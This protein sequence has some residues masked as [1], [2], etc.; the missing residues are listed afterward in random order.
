MPDGSVVIPPALPTKERIAT[1]DAC[2][3][4]PIQTEHGGQRILQRPPAPGLQASIR[5][6]EVTV[7]ADTGRPP[8]MCAPAFLVVLLTDTRGHGAVASR[9]VRVRALG[10]QR[11]VLTSPA[12]FSAPP[13]VVRAY[14][15][16]ADGRESLVS[17][18]LVR[19]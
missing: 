3:A 10:P 19:P 17:S 16:T 2:D 11:L 6:T 7:D 13:D 15:A 1:S 9:R 4:R 18:V 14:V 8:A 12:S 5:G